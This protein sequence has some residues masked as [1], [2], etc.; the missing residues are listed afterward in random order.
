MFVQPDSETS[1]ELLVADTSPELSDEAKLGQKAARAL[2]RAVVLLES[3]PPHTG[4]N[5]PSRDAM[6]L[7]VLALCTQGDL[8]KKENV[9]FRTAVLKRR[10]TFLLHAQYYSYPAARWFQEQGVHGYETELE[11]S[12][13]KG[14]WGRTKADRAAEQAA[15]S[16]LQNQKDLAKALTTFSSHLASRHNTPR[17]PKTPRNTGK[18]TPTKGKPVKPGKGKSKAMQE[19]SLTSPALKR[20]DTG[21]TQVLGASQDE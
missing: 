9:Q 2:H 3:K 7:S 10:A 19:A 16:A 6:E 12:V 11:M 21:S 18:A 13:W 17:P 4:K 14:K 8:S 20:S 1:L 5:K 15:T